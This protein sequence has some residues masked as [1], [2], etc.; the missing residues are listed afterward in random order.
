MADTVSRVHS[1]GQPPQVGAGGA[2]GSAVLPP[3]QPRLPVDLAGAGAV[4]R[5]TEV[6]L[7]SP[8]AQAFRRRLH[9]LTIAVLAVGA[10]A[11]ALYACQFHFRLALSVLGASAAIAAASSAIGA[12]V[13]FLFGVPKS[14]QGERGQGQVGDYANN[15]N[16]EQVSD[17][18]TKI[19]I[20]IGLV[21]IAAAPAALG[22]LATEL[23]PALGN[24]ATSA[25]FAL[26]L[27]LY[28]AVAGL[29][30]AY[31]W[32]A[33]V[34]KGDLETVNVELVAALAANRAK[35]LAVQEAT[36]AARDVAAD[37]A[38]QVA[39]GV[40]TQRAQSVAK[41]VV[42]DVV[43]G[44]VQHAAKDAADDNALAQVL[45]DRQLSGKS[46]PGPDELVAAIARA[47]PDWR[48][49]FYHR[50]EEIRDR[51]WETD[52][53]TMSRTIPVFEALVANDHE[54]RFFRHFGSLAYALKDKV[55]PDYARALDL[56]TTA[57][58]LRDE[59]GKT[60]SPYLEWNRALCRIRLDQAFE[61]D[62]PTPDPAREAILAD[63]R[64]AARQLPED[65]FQESGAKVDWDAV[66]RW[67]ALQ[68]LTAADLR[69]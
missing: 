39:A 48:V 62:E 28:F 66:G 10:L 64:V 55:P 33:L 38:Q 26:S 23:S 67:L 32:T 35:D 57:I 2:L 51:T 15:T 18:L 17:W 29:L 6:D 58:D 52:K 19:L 43:T 5:R 21:Q 1:D 45:V 36:A 69:G 34:L 22:R 53:E 13:G 60:G 9:R 61:A 16:L 44:A 27:A 31:L 46:P 41:D 37:Q 40:A 54:H 25:V 4:G 12:F 42:Q 7:D 63:L 65:H 8:A 59:Q 30:I 3:E 68:G 47:T 56:L 20:G 50:A 14:R 49:T 11:I 24:L